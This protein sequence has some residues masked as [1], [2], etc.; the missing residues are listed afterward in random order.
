MGQIQEVKDLE[1]HDKYFT[2]EWLSKLLGVID[3]PRD[4]CLFTLHA[5][6]GVR[7]SDLLGWDIR[8]EEFDNNRI[9]L[10]DY[11][12]DVYRWV[13]FPDHCK[14]LIKMW[15]KERQNKGIKSN[16]LF[17]IS[18]Q[19]YNRVVKKWAKKVGHP[20]ATQCSTHWFRHTFI[21]LSLKAGRDMTTVRQNTGDSYKTIHQWY[22]GYGMD[23]M[24][25]EINNKRLL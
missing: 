22:T 3:N 25:E 17:N 21:R 2:Q 10:L 7:A 5:E 13:Y 11:K 16:K 24:K 9:K 1:K 12:K 4:K 19:H 6:T 14:P 20:L 18:I 8:H 23:D 15:K